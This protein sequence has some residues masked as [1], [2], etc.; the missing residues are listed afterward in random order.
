MASDHK[1]CVLHQLVDRG[2]AI[3][4]G[5][6]L[7]L[8]AVRDNDLIL[9]SKDNDETY[10]N[11]LLIDFLTKSFPANGGM[12]ENERISLDGKTP[13]GYHVKIATGQFAGKRTWIVSREL[14]LLLLFHLDG[15]NLHYCFS[16]S[17]TKVWLVSFLHHQLSDVLLGSIVA[18]ECL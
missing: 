18:V 17:Q 3:R 8:L 2:R 7:L 13:R 16:C 1:D 5:K 10:N 6:Y 11:Q 4:T 14:S 15:I 12:Y 9:L